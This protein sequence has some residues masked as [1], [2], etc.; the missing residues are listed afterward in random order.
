[1]DEWLPTAKANT[2]PTA[3]DRR[4]IAALEVWVSTQPAADDGTD[5]SL[6]N[7]SGRGENPER[8]RGFRPPL[9][10][11]RNI[12]MNKILPPAR[13]DLWPDYERVAGEVLTPESRFLARAGWAELFLTGAVAQVRRRC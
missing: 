11:S 7:P 5:G 12:C 3:D 1:V 10:D 9:S 4:L 2:K 13:P 6:T 8:H